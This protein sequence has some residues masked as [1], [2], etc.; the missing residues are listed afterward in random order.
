MKKSLFVGSRSLDRR[1][2]R[3]SPDLGGIPSSI[4]LGFLTLCHAGPAGRRAPHAPRGLLRGR[5]ERR[6]SEQR[7]ERGYVRTA[8]VP[9]HR[10]VGTAVADRCGHAGDRRHDDRHGATH[11]AA[12]RRERLHPLQ[13]SAG[14][15]LV[16]DPGSVGHF[17]IPGATNGFDA[18]DLAFTT[19]R[20]AAHRSDRREH[21]EAP[22]T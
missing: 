7:R 5:R 21:D 11:A 2:A 22:A 14:D 3:V 16:I 4:P 1:W 20:L 19:R 12:D 13:A 9:R 17:I 6:Y 18:F 10:R 15:S 8:A